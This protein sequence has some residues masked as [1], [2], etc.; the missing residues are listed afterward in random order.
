MLGLVVFAK[1]GN[2]GANARDVGGGDSRRGQE[3]ER[4][5]KMKA[6]VLLR[7]FKVVFGSVTLFPKNERML[8]PHLQTI[9][10]SCL[11]YTTRVKDPTNYYFLL[12]ALF[13]SISGGKFES[14]YKVRRCSPSGEARR[15]LNHPSKSRGVFGI[16][17]LSLDS[18][19]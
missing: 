16:R 7:L 10:L 12:R 8:R 18:G 4:R 14:S 2:R 9:V 5:A 1:P 19:G 3:Q 17:R 11:R 15:V 6:Q 13:R